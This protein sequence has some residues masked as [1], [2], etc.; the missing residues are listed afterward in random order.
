MG[1]EPTWEALTMPAIYYSSERRSWVY[2]DTFPATTG[3]VDAAGLAELRDRYPGVP[4]WVQLA[5]FAP[6]LDEV[7]RHGA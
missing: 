6:E 1:A 5:A 4:V 3:Q 2:V 7:L